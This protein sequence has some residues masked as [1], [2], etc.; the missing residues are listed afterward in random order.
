MCTIVS[1][2]HKAI[3]RWHDRR[4]D[5]GGGVEAKGHQGAFA[6]VDVTVWNIDGC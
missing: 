6:R 2:G 4:T 1:D 5:T 3:G